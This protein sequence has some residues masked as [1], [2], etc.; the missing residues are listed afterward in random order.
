MPMH[1]RYVAPQ[2]AVADIVLRHSPESAEIENLAETI[3]ALL[4]ENETVGLEDFSANWPSVSPFHG[5]IME[6]VG[7]STPSLFGRHA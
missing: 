7:Q 6:I 4:S 2:V 5:E 1:E 3:R